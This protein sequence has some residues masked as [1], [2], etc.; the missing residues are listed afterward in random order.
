M[1]C[2]GR[3]H[4]HDRAAMDCLGNTKTSSIATSNG[5]FQG[6]MGD[7]LTLGKKFLR[8]PPRVDF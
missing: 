3:D 5:C 7:Q 1:D 2:L 6:P 4:A 8:R